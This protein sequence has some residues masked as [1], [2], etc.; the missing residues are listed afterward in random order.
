MEG[1]PERVWNSVIGGYQV[2][3]KWLSYRDQ[4]ILGRGLKVDEVHEVTNIA[5][6]ITAIILMYPHLDKN[7]ALVKENIGYKL[8][9]TSVSSNDIVLK[10][11]KLST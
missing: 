2:I 5:R 9:H 7:Y 1:I 11:F 8:K 10:F 4:K 6:R 3:K